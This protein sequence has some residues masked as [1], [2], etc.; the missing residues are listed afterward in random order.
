MAVSIGTP[1]SDSFSATADQDFFDAGEG[2]DVISY[3]AAPGGVALVLDL[4][5]DGATGTAGWA[6]GDIVRGTEGFIGSAFDDTVKGVA[7]PPGA[8]FSLP[9]VLDGAD[10]NDN[11]AGGWKGDSLLGGAGNDTLDS[12]GGA[13]TLDGG[14]GFD[15]VTFVYALAGGVPL[16][17]L[18]VDLRIT[19]VQQIRPGEFVQFVGI[20]G[21]DLAGT[22]LAPEA[23]V[24]ETLIG[25]DAANFLGATGEVG[26]GD[27]LQ[28]NGGDDTLFGKGT[29][30]GGVGNDVLRGALAIGGAGDD[31]YDFGTPRYRT[32]GFNIVELRNEGNDTV[33]VQRNASLS[34]WQ[35]VENIA[36][37]EGF[38]ATG[39]NGNDGA[40]RLTGNSADNFLN[41]NGGND[42][43]D[44]G[45]GADT[46]LGGAGRD[47]LLVDNAG[48]Q[49]IESLGEGRDRVI[50]SIS[51]ALTANVEELELTGTAVNG[52]GNILANRII[53]NDLGNGIAGGDGGDT[54]N[55]GGGND[56]LSGD[57]GNDSLS[58]GAAQ[59]LLIGGDGADLL[60][61]GSGADIFAWALAADGR[62][63]LID[64][65]TGVDRL[66]MSA[67][68]FGGGL[69]A[70]M[71]MAATGRFVINATGRADQGFGQFVLEAP[72][73]QLFWDADGTGAGARVKIA[74]LG[75]AGLAATDFLIVS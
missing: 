48:D 60:S 65:L 57:V 28:G 19:A 62:D 70:D 15:V 30:E 37:A 9:F 27:L 50:A 74:L 8:G 55:G 36:L 26:G 22:Q 18:H 2:F 1:G 23:G 39:A 14:A 38:G 10:G 53:G 17:A 43:M 49:V 25:D 21:V 4:D 63:T 54:L 58:G 6:D 59:D 71:D 42:T 31:I 68:G 7:L 47:V 16:P 34:E 73:G 3:A 20:E 29:V 12:Q 44:G 33:I 67:A 5:G 11:L 45:V 35:Y 41:G 72:T 64:F 51:Y 32:V 69:T 52:T 66:Q 46:M 24:L 56:S 61:G 75:T 13:D 40:N